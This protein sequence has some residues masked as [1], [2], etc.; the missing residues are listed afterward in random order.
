M[1]DYNLQ[2]QNKEVL[3]GAEKE[4][5]EKYQHFRMVLYSGM[6]DAFLYYLNTEKKLEFL[7]K[8]EFREHVYEE[9]SEAKFCGEWTAKTF[10][11]LENMDSELLFAWYI[12]AH[13]LNPKQLNHLSGCI[14]NYIQYI[15]NINLRA[16]KVGERDASEEYREKIEL[17]TKVV[18]VLEFVMIFCGQISNEQ[19][20]YFVVDEENDYED[21]A[22]H[23]SKYVDFLTEPGRG[24]AE[25]LKMFCESEIKI[26]NET[27]KIG[28]Y[29]DNLNPIMNRNVIMASMYGQESILADCMIPVTKNDLVQYYQ[30][31]KELESVFK[32]NK[33]E[34]KTEQIKLKQFQNLKNRIELLDVMTYTEIMNELYGKLISWAYLR[35]R[36]LMYFQLGFHYLRLFYGELKESE[37]WQRTLKGDEISIRDG[38]LLYQIAAMYR[39]E[40][41]VYT[42]DTNGAAVKPKNSS[43]VGAGIK[44]FYEGYC[45]KDSSI[46]ESGLCL[47]EVLTQHDE[48]VKQ[49][50]AIDHFRYYSKTDKSMMDLYFMI[51]QSF[52]TYDPKLRKSVSFNFKNI[53][54][55]YFV[56]ANTEMKKE[57]ESKMT[58]SKKGLVSDKMYYKLET[59]KG[60]GTYKVEIDARS[61]IFLEQL[62]KLLEYKK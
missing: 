5:K 38:V 18:R 12:T 27:T 9:L 37:T 48:I 2:N 25:N 51:Y 60:N 36:D 49:R 43:S 52:F 54:K 22:N 45:K 8:P 11:D 17:Y 21:Y 56:I 42:L 41:P 4:E 61:P 39:Y 55:R 6:K 34:N 62:K 10:A 58:F 50:N 29:Q 19:S 28:I 40:L 33:C 26:K 46:Y 44:A 7:K 14:R 15:E 32:K 30:L 24:K 57:E 23:L 16:V 3:S 47:F 1:T 35:E 13:F 31:K 59:Q 53:L 20:D